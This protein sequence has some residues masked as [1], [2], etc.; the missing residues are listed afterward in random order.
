MPPR[1]MHDQL[2]VVIDL[3]ALDALPEKKRPGW[4]V[5][6]TAEADAALVKYWKVKRQPD[7]AKIL[8]RSVSACA[9]RYEELTA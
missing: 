5:E 4:P 1:L 8:C 3:S 7:V 9:K 6:W 2:P